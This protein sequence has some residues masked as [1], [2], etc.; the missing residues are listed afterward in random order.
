MPGSPSDYVPV[1]RTFR[2]L[3]DEEIADIE[4]ASALVKFGWAH[5][6]GW[7]EVLR[8]PRVLLISEAGAGKTRECQAQ[9]DRL[10]AAGQTAF[11]FDLATLANTAL[12]DTLLPN[13]ES[14]FDAWLASQSE[15]ATFFLDSIDELKLTL[16]NFAVALTRFA[17]ALG[18]QIAR[19]RIVVTT[20]P[21]PFDRALI[22]RHLPIP[23]PVEAVPTAV[24][25]ADMMMARD[26][27]TDHDKDSRKAKA[28]RNVGLMPLSQE[29]RRLLAIGQGVTDPDALLEDIRA[30]DAEEFAERPQDLIELCADWRDH[31]RI[32][33]HRDQVWADIST[34]LKPRIDRQERVELTQEA[35]VEGA[36]R[37]ALAAMLI[38][39]LTLRYDAES[40]R[41]PASE[42]ALDVSKVL[43]D[44]DAQAQA[45]L[46]ER[47]LFGFASYGRV[48]F[49]HRSVVE[50][51]AANRLHVL[52]ARGSS[53]KAIKRLLFAET[54]QGQK[55]VRPSM[56]PVAAWLASWR[57]TFFDDLVQ[58][59]P[60][61]VL[62]YGDP[63]SLSIA[64]RTRALE[65]YVK[66]YGSGSWR[67][68]QTPSIQVHRFAAIE[69]C[70]PVAELWRCGIENPEVRIIILKL[71]AAGKLIASGDLAFATSMDRD[72]SDQERLLAI[73]VLIQ[74]GDYRIDNVSASIAND[75]GRWPPDVAR[76]AMV[77]LFPAYMPIDRIKCIVLRVPDNRNSLGEYQYYLSNAVSNYDLAPSYLDELRDAICEIVSFRLTWD[78]GGYPHV[79]TGRSDLLPVLTA[80]CVRQSSEGVASEAWLR[81]S[82]LA[83]RLSK[84]E[85]D[86]EKPVA[87]L[88]RALGNL[89]STMREGGF[90]YEADL[91]E[92]LRPSRDAY[93]RLFE[94]I[95]E[96]GIALND[97]KDSAWVRR[98]LSNPTEPLKNREM[99]LWAEMVFLHDKC[100][101]PHALLESLKQHVADSPIL[102]NLIEERMKPQKES[103]EIR[104]WEVRS[105]KHKEKEER[106][107][108]KAHA[109]WVA[110][111]Q[112]ISRD[113]E[114]VFHPDRADHTAWNLWRAMERS[115]KESRA[116]GWNRHLIEQQFGKP[117]ADQLREI[118]MKAWRADRPTFASER[119]DGEKN[120]F[121]VRWQFGLAGI[122]AEA[123]DPNWAECLTETEAE[124]ACRYVPVQFNGF[125]FWLERLAIQHPTVIDRV[126]GT[127]LSLSLRDAA[128]NRYGMTLQDVLYAPPILAALFAPRIRAWL[129][130]LDAIDAAKEVPQSKYRIQQAIDV[131]IK[132]GTD[133]DRRFLE[134]E[135][136]RYLTNGDTFGDPWLSTMLHL[137]PAAGVEALE[138]RL[139]D[140]VPSQDGPGVALFARLFDRDRSRGV[141]LGG[142]G[143]APTM[144]LRLLRLAYQHI[145]RED[146]AHREDRDS[147]DT[148]EHAER[149]RNAILSA[150]FAAPGSD[151]WKA[152]LEMA[153]DPLF[154]HLRDRTLAVAAEKAAEEADGAALTEGEFA[155]LDKVGEAPPASRDAMFAVMRDRLDD[156]DDLL[157]QDVSPREAWAAIKDERVMR[158][159]LARTLRDAARNAYTVDQEAVTADEK[160]T[161]IRLRSAVSRQQ[162]TIELKLADDRSGRDLFD[163]LREQ[164]LKKYMAAEDCR[165]GCLMVTIARGR[166]WEHPQTSK[167]IDFADL[168]DVLHEEADAIAQEMSGTVRLMVKGL[169]LRPR[170]SRE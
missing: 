109:S 27:Q 39:K 167:L 94:L 158:R 67:G 99:M 65:A 139:K 78:D 153:N 46:L 104:A 71:I 87:K 79:R 16:G 130:E 75:A 34:K 19:A 32:R 10:L 163:T 129:A 72:G 159:E 84:N 49:H 112:E 113:P 69:L 126:L 137:N 119:P 33:S 105:A 135:A 51:L 110:F 48:R 148:R 2:D 6:V 12:R 24:A 106:K 36:S 124:L 38:R 128:G 9:R 118:M 122:A 90:L 42:P 81:S 136:A 45:T 7:D 144:L 97:E 15:I 58:L 4:K 1:N 30:R 140:E 66:R 88:R 127:E 53:I 166:Q 89:P 11:F 86:D 147:L 164:L 20:R 96:K 151:G 155:I 170:L 82:L 60:A 133:D 149:V 76:R 85:H 80:S 18:G 150:L 93:H 131:L 117:V 26:T 35:A 61:V 134:A 64:Q 116:S 28:W 165:A 77:R 92:R 37:L 160:E 143:F 31:H 68:L 146:D 55:V 25:F 8:S 161:D 162:A 141:D 41:I 125:P 74:L 123:E 168:M 29:Q 43:L 91:L 107:Q 70:Q 21:V 111:W 22:E 108:A 59:D 17:K 44:W 56:R 145:R 100:S 83:V 98:R 3:S 52:L 5:S 142:T 50:F 132:S 40:D 152:K 14:R 73:D 154:E 114:P 47:P 54:A 120:S 121:L 115:G 23:S 103:R 138:R 102:T 62:D 169:D 13:E 101:D 156:V 63:Q 95:H 57:E 157:L